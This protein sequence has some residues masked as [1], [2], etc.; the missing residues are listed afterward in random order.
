MRKKLKK[1]LINEKCYRD[2]KA[3]IN[4]KY[5]FLFATISIGEKVYDWF[6]LHYFQNPKFQP[7]QIISHMFMHGDF[8]HIFLICLD[9]GCLELL[10][11]KCGEGINL[12][13]FIYLQV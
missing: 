13:F 4:Y 12:S 11:S 10:L 9:Y 1:K 7:W 2:C 6:A 5:N 8:A 3:L